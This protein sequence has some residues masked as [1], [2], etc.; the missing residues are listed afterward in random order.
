MSS[1]N[2]TC[3]TTNTNL[4]GPKP[5]DHVM[6][7]DADTGSETDKDYGFKVVNLIAWY[8]KNAGAYPGDPY[9]HNNFRKYYSDY[10][11]AV[12]RLVT[13]SEND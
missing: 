13:Y 10:H 12:I 11:P 8:S 3:V 9:H 1:L 7:F 5:Y 4:N 6:Y 2:D